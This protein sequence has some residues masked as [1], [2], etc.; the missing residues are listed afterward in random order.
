MTPC[1]AS[2]W[3]SCRTSLGRR[4]TNEPRKLGIAQKEQRRSQPLA[5]LSGAIGPASRRRRTA[6]GPVA[7]APAPI[8][9]RSRPRAGPGARAPRSPEASRSTGEIGSS[10]RRS[11]GVC[12]VVG[13][14]RHDRPQAGRDVGVVVEAEDRV[15]LGERLGEVLAVALGQAADCDD[16]LGAAA[17]T[18]GRL[19]VG[20]LEQRVHR[21]LL[22][23][24]DES[25]GVD[26]DRVGVLG[27]VDEHEAAGLEPSGELLGVD[28]V[29]GAAE[30]HDGDVQSGS[31]GARCQ[32]SSRREYAG[33]GAP[34]RHRG[35]GDAR[36]RTPVSLSAAR[37]RHV[38]RPP[39]TGA[40]ESV[41]GSVD[42]EGALAGDAGLA[43]RPGVT[44][45]QRD[46][47]GTV[48]GLHAHRAARP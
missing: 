47:D 42:D 32:W 29:A 13:L 43:D 4:L 17:V 23:G 2:H 9:A 46:G 7:G 18:G 31:G 24:L 22:G 45:G 10:R 3:P 48:G 33:S 27:V 38:G 25:A 41:A 19:E 34:G 44:A 26:H 16:G 21:V 5:S 15:G 28:L 40:L 6:R 8:S 39:A 35:R 30:G 12:G 20:R 37:R 11:D 14:P 1:V 36:S